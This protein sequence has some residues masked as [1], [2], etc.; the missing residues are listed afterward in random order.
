MCSIIVFYF[1]FYPSY[2]FN[3]CFFYSHL[4]KINSLIKKKF[5]AILSEKK[6][7]KFLYN[8]KKNKNEKK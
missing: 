8:S 1:Y 4:Q 3:I 2:R 7:V 6:L 5:K